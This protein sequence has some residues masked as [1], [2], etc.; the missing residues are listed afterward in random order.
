ME[1]ITATI[2]YISS[3]AAYHGIVIV[4][5]IML[6]SFIKTDHPAHPCHLIQ[7]RPVMMELPGN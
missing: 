3:G 1:A 5:I 2:M 7:Q 4:P 6:L